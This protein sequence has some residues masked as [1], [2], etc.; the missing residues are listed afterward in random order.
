[1]LF[2]T[3]FCSLNVHLSND[4]RYNV[5]AHLVL[6]YFNTY[7]FNLYWENIPPFGRE[8]AMCQKRVFQLIFTLRLQWR[9]EI[10]LNCYFGSS[11]Y[12]SVLQS[13]N[14]I[15]SWIISADLFIN[16]NN[17]VPTGFVSPNYEFLNF[18]PK[19]CDSI[20]NM[21]FESVSGGNKI[22]REKPYFNILWYSINWWIVF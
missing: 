1:M 9:L 8:Q 15:D 21:K 19:G 4:I 13:R 2:T 5:Y 3:L 7:L 22:N 18:S 17:L 10:T 14:G 6:F 16:F 11:V 12:Y 20:R